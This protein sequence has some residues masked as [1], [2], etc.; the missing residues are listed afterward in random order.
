MSCF[1]AFLTKNWA[2]MVN[3][4]GQND[5]KCGPERACCGAVVGKVWAQFLFEGAQLAGYGAQLPK[6][7]AKTVAPRARS[8]A[9]GEGFVE[10]DITFIVGVTKVL[11]E[12]IL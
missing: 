7:G 6:N 4:G 8:T 5:G 2:T 9:H 11:H 1:G 10:V 12:N 3:T